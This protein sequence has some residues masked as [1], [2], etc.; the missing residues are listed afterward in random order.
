M[1][2]DHV[3]SPDLPWR[4]EEM[5]YSGPDGKLGEKS[6]F[7]KKLKQGRLETLAY[8]PTSMDVMSQC[9]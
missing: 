6:P 7:L 9:V 1:R 5:E 4:L 8:L 3:R 2:S